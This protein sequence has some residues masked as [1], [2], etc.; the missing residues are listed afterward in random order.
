LVL[1][2]SDV[3]FDFER[4]TRAKLDELVE[5][6]LREK[7]LTGF[8][9]WLSAGRWPKKNGYDWWWENAPRMVERYAA[10]REITK[11]E[12]ADFNGV[13]G[14]ECDLS[15]MFDFGQLRGAP[16]RVFRLPSGPLV[17]ADVKSGSTTPKEPLQLGTYANDL[18]ML[19]FERPAYGTYV[20]VKNAPDEGGF[21]HTPLIPLDKYRTPYLE[22]IYGAVDAT[23]KLGAFVPNVGDACRTC[24]VQ[25]ACYAAG[26]EDSQRYDRLHPNY[27]G[28]PI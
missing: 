27:Q 26:G 13:P 11:W 19:G 24:P 23:I 17:V 10:W 8:D 5:K 25:R 21:L 2:K 6:E 3:R 12:V 15:V 28:S 18:E 20:M 22:Q 16:D 9:S 1:S 14:I 4:E 7:N